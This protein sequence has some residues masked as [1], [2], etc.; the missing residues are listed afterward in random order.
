MKT[1]PKLPGGRIEYAS[2]SDKDGKCRFTLFWMADYHP[3]HP[4][5]ENRLAER[6]QAF[7]ADPRSYGYPRPEET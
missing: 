5:G 2:G 6:G 4:K 1:K 3:G 7:H